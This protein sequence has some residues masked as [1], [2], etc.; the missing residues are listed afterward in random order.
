MK[1]QLLTVVQDGYKSRYYFM[2]MMDFFHHTMRINF[3]RV[4][5]FW[6]NYFTG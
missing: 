6:W 5:T 4:A 1:M 2:L 3:R